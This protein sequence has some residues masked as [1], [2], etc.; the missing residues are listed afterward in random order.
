MTIIPNHKK[1]LKSKEL[2]ILIEKYGL[3][4]VCE[5]ISRSQISSLNFSSNKIL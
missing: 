5:E 4:K 1:N 3:E 2:K